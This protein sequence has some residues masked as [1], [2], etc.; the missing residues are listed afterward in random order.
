MVSLLSNRSTGTLTTLVS[1]FL[2]L[3]SCGNTEE[4]ETDTKPPNIIFLLMDD[5]RW[6]TMGV[7]GNSIIQ[8]PNMDRLANEGT[9]FTNA[10]VT[11]AICVAS[12]ASI[13][14]GQYVSRHGINSFI[15]TLKYDKLVDTYPL[16]LKKK[17]GYKIGFIGKYGVGLVQPSEYFDY[18]A[19]EKIQQ[20]EYET[21]DENGDSI[22]YTDL[23][24]KRMDTFLDS[25]GNGAPFCLSVSFKA[26]HVQDKDPR[27]FLYADRYKDLYADVEI[28][29]PS[30]IK[31]TYEETFPEAFKNPIFEG[32]TLIN[33]SRKRC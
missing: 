14:T 1:L 27:Q 29:V 5:Q 28:P 2:I 20:P 6:D 21:V 17:K 18:W 33:E 31:D 3:G 32:D 19:A 4:K 16:Q 10:Q 8:T 23:V 22:H 7:M 24:S 12:R 11:T 15:D 25:L 30:H 13:L 9:L 26:P